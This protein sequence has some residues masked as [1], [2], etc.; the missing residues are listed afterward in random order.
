M[1]LIRGKIES[2]KLD[3]DELIFLGMIGAE[4]RTKRAGSDLMKNAKRTERFGMRG[5]S[6][7]RLQ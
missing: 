3:R 7:F 4:D 5:A 6:G 2:E 1:H